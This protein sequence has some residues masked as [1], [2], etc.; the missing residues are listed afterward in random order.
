MLSLCI[1]HS[2]IFPS[3]L[4]LFALIEAL[5]I[6]VNSVLTPIDIISLEVYFNRKK[7]VPPNSKPLEII[8]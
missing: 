4:K 8:S 6:E 5:L 1:K 7:S 3:A 2:S